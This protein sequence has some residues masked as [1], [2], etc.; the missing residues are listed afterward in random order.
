[1]GYASGLRI[2]FPEDKFSLMHRMKE[3]VHLF[4]LQ[5]LPR[6]ICIGSVL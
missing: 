6:A 5:L 4:V 2:S 1:M 3:V